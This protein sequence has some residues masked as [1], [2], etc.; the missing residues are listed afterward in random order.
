MIADNHEFCPPL[1]L[2]IAGIDD[3]R[4]FKGISA[5][6]GKVVALCAA[7]NNC[8]AEGACSAD[9]G[10]KPRINIAVSAALVMILSTLFLDAATLDAICFLCWLN[11]HSRGHEA[12]LRW[13][14]LYRRM[15][16]AYNAIAEKHCGR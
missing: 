2:W 1:E 5:G 15:S 13:V 14:L 11:V 3:Q 4:G 6:R 10:I 12:Q 8:C 16:P 9:A 7:S